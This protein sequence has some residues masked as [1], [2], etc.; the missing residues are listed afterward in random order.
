M[1]KADLNKAGWEQG[2]FPILCETCEQSFLEVFAPWCGTPTPDYLSFPG[3][4]DNAFV[5]MVRLES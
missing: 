1:P 2:D 3:L 5:R 4:G